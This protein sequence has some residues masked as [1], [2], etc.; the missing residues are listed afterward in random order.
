MVSKSKFLVVLKIILLFYLFLL[1]IEFIGVFTNSLAG[2]WLGKTLGSATNPLLGVF[3]GIIITSIIQSSSV[4]TSVTVGLVAGNIISL[5][6]AVGIIFG[7]NLGTSVTNSLFSLAYFRQKGKFELAFSYS[8]LND[9]FNI[10]SLVVLFPL[11]YFFHPIEKLSLATASIIPSNIIF[12]PKLLNY[13]TEP[14]ISSIKLVIPWPSAFLLLALFG[15]IFALQNFTHII[16]PWINSKAK[17][18]IN[19]TLL[20]NTLLTF[21]AGAILTIF[22]QSSSM[23]SSFV[24]PF[25]ASGL[26]DLV[27][28]FPYL[29]GSNIGT[30]FTALLAATAT[31]SPLA[32]AAALAHLYYNLIGTILV[33]F[34]YHLPIFLA[35]TVADFE[36]RHRWFA[37]VYLVG[38]FFVIPIAGIL[39]LSLI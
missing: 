18:K 24:I 37:P 5:T 8:I 25:M 10:L 38:L 20:G 11:E 1:S 2:A 19:S 4:T 7:A 22:I 28:I 14:V 16:K 35:Q 23:A 3:L 32:L 21:L 31:G 27:R 6:T 29:L 26:I 36:S 9:I 33:I 12:L 34:I 17:D 13:L 15:I 39:L 30:T